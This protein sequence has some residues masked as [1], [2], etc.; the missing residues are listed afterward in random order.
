MRMSDWSSDVC[1]SDL[2]ARIKGRGAALDRQDAVI[3][4]VAVGVGRNLRQGQPRRKIDMGVDIRQFVGEHGRAVRQEA[5]ACGD[6]L[7]VAGTG[8]ASCRANGWQ[9]V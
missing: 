9:Y 2:P 6:K 1:S 7:P 8:R 4:A 3:E 5:I